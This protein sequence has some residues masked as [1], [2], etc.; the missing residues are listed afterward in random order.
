MELYIL[1]NGGFAHELFEQIS[2]Q[3]TTYGFS[4][5]IVIKDGEAFVINEEGV[6]PFLYPESASFVIGT[7]NVA[8]RKSF[9]DFFTARYEPNKTHFPNVYS[10]K[11]YISKTA[12]LGYGNVFSPF[13]IINGNSKVGNFNCFNIHSSISGNSIICN[14]N[15]LFP[16]ACIMG[17]C[18]IGSY[19]M[20][21]THS[22]ITQGLSIGNNNTISH[23]ECLF[24][25]LSS[26]E[27]FQSGIILKKKDFE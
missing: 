11:A 2:L 5:F 25:E 27:I 7:N 12:M 9:I 15:L 22:T 16:Y 4:G 3:D 20:L 21:G 19:N 13:S 24:D 14:N 18:L 26:N 1:G 17:N 8:R 6:T 10:S 23:G